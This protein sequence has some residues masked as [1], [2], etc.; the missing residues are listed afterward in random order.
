MGSPG[1]GKTLIARVIAQEADAYFLH[2]SG[3]GDYA[4]ILR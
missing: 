4:Q 3:T 1:T 2:L